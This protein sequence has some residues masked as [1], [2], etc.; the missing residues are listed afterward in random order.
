MNIQ[1]QLI[2]FAEKFSLKEKALDAIDKV[3]DAEIKARK[4]FGFDLLDGLKKSELIYEFCRYEFR[5]KSPENCLFVT[6]I[7]IY[8]KYLYGPEYDIPVGYYEER[9]DLNGEFL[10]DLILFEVLLMH[11]PDNQTNLL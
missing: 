11:K 4:K 8:S 7:N 1:N 2:E 3:L 6:R 9:T 5:V 10:T